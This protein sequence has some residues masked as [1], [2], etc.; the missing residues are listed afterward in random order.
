MPAMMRKRQENFRPELHPLAAKVSEALDADVVVFAGGVFPFDE[1]RFRTTI[2]G[3]AATR[4]KNVLLLLTTFGGSA[5]SAYRMARCLQ[6]VYKPG[7]ILIF[8][9][10]YCKSAGTLLAVGADEIVMSDC[11]EFGPIDVQ[12]T[13]PD[14]FGERMSGLT[15]TQA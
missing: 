2:R 11:A 4:K 5:D 1:D 14:E 8:V 15:A 9:D 6:E 7:E 10:T 13:K 3:N 12:L